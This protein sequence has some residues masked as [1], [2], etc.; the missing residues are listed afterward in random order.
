MIS[1]EDFE[2]HI[3][4]LKR[5]EEYVQDLRR[6]YHSYR[7]V[8]GDAEAPC[9]G[10]FFKQIE[11]L[12]LLFGIEQDSSGYS[13]LLWWIEDTEFG[14][15]PSNPLMLKTVAPGEKFDFS[16]LR[17]IYDF[18]VKEADWTFR[19]NLVN[20]IEEHPV[21][22]QFIGE[23]L[24]LEMDTEIL[25]GLNRIILDQYGMT[26]EGLIRRFFTWIAEKPTEFEKWVKEKAD[27]DKHAG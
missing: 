10:S 20:M 8:V 2:Q 24:L 4:F 22:A 21:K 14:K 17:G 6:L 11:L 9:D 13:T 27:A 7:D 26:V 15:K 23:E 16:T 12:D 1:Y 18:L 19:K 25:D 3:Q 5:Q